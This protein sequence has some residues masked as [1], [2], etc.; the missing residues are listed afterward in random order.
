MNRNC[1]YPLTAAAIFAADTALKQLA[2]SDRLTD[3]QMPVVF[4]KSHNY[5]AFMNLGSDRPKTVTAL[6]SLMT[7]GLIVYAMAGSKEN[8]ALS[9]A[10]LSLMIGGSCSNVFDRLKQGYVTDYI[11]FK[12]RNGKTSD[13]VYN[14]G[15][16]AIFSGCV[17]TAASLLRK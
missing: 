14:I 1:I 6:S 2:E 4:R 13:I 9:K 11:S 17:L 7:A 15:D 5:G 12:K 3:K 10:G 16:F 8:D